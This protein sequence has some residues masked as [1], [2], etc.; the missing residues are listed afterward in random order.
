[1]RTLGL[2][3]LVL[4]A[5]CAGRGD[6]RTSGP[7][8]A[9]GPNDT[10]ARIHALIGNPDCTEDSQC[11]SLPVGQ[12]PCGGPESYLAYST[13]RSSEAELKALGATYQAERRQANTQAGRIS[14]CRFTMDPGAVCRAGKCELGAGQPV[15]R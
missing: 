10:L 12:R 15:A 3:S 4:L 14:D 9:L 5:A 2:L 13:A 6:A 8:A 7:E 1:M 11:R